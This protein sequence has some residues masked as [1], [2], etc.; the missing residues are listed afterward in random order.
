MIGYD[1]KGLFLQPMISWSDSDIVY[2]LEIVGQMKLPR[3]TIPISH[4]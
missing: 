3:R 4:V 1:W 2:G